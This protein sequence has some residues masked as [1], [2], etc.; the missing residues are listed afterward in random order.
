MRSLTRLFALQC[1]T[2]GI[3]GP[4]AD[5]R[6]LHCPSL[7]RLPYPFL[8]RF[9]SLP[10]GALA[11]LR[12][13]SAEGEKAEKNIR[14]DHPDWDPYLWKSSSTALARRGGG[15]ILPDHDAADIGLSQFLGYTVLQLSKSGCCQQRVDYLQAKTTS[16]GHNHKVGL[17]VCCELPYLCLV[18]VLATSLS[19]THTSKHSAAYI[20]SLLFAPHDRFE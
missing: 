18:R 12:F 19:C 17:Q 8:P 7:R 20:H 5:R 14:M 11:P 3:F 16:P 1:C 13:F 6:Y 15:I 4:Y 2:R 9:I 10:P